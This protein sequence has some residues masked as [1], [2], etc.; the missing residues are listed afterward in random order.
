MQLEKEIELCDIL[1]KFICGGGRWGGLRW[2]GGGGKK[3]K[4][5]L[6]QQ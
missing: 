6:E 5:V 4:T 2:W 1:R 3:Q